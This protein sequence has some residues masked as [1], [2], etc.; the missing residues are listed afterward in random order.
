MTG[1]LVGTEIS[2][3]LILS[4]APDHTSSYEFCNSVHRCAPWSIFIHR[5]YS[6]IDGM[7]WK[8]P[9]PHI[10]ILYHGYV[11]WLK[12]PT[13]E[14][15]RPWSTLKQICQ[16]IHDIEIGN[17]CCHY[18]MLFLWRVLADMY[19][20]WYYQRPLYCGFY[21][22]WIWYIIHGCVLTDR[23]FQYFPIAVTKTWR[24]L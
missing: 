14:E 10:T 1:W 3:P 15:N 13:K 7:W 23:I 11:L 4:P 5:I 6:N 21:L 9:R 22:W 8:A 19:C 24:Y 12:C 16:I 17:G 2:R 18:G 20:I